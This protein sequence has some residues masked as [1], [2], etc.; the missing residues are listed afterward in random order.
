MSFMD[1]LRKEK[2]VDEA[3]EMAARLGLD[4]EA[5][6]TQTPIEEA[7]EYG[8]RNN[9]DINPDWIKSGFYLIE[10]QQDANTIDEWVE[11]LAK[12]NTN[13]GNLVELVDSNYPERE[14]ENIFHSSEPMAGREKMPKVEVA[15]HIQN[16]FTNWE[17]VLHDIL[18]LKEA[19][20]DELGEE[21]ET[22]RPE[23]RHRKAGVKI[24]PNPKMPKG[25]SYDKLGT[26]IMNSFVPVYDTLNFLYRKLV[27][28]ELE[29]KIEKPRRTGS[30]VKTIEEHK[31]KREDMANH[32]GK[33]LQFHVD[34]KGSKAAD[35]LELVDDSI[36]VNIQ[37]LLLNGHSNLHS[38]IRT[39][40][41]PDGSSWDRNAK[42]WSEYVEYNDQKSEDVFNSLLLR[43][44]KKMLTTRKG[45]AQL[46]SE[47]ED[48]ASLN[49]NEWQ[50]D[51]DVWLN[52][53][54]KD[55]SLPPEDEHKFYKK[56]LFKFIAKI[57]GDAQEDKRSKKALGVSLRDVERAEFLYFLLKEFGKG[58]DI[59]LMVFDRLNESLKNSKIKFDKNKEFTV[60]T[61]TGDE[62]E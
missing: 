2:E 1:I 33:M 26:E 10:S 8:I 50:N 43:N 36:L 60:E 12:A 25:K 19:V 28:T 61:P 53:Y 9:S 45:E 62:E 40:F 52:D 11:R 47:L 30:D 27:N 49:I 57:R 20:K 18:N 54:K 48:F 23:Y 38:K 22:E 31:K 15:K 7:I 14:F 32:V 37:R 16:D 21:M 24:H 29:S 42:V 34:G 3:A 41:I 13:A 39:K 59:Q 46:V 4:G 55:G 17:E 51:I 58:S 35:K 44:K 56:A 5:T 6:S